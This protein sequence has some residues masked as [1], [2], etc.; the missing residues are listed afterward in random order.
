MIT[1]I[2]ELEPL[3]F[4]WRTVPTPA[5]PRVRLRGVTW[6]GNLLVLCFVL[7]FGIWSAFASLQSAAIAPGVV[8]LEFE[9]EDD[10]A[11]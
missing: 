3:E 4:A 8:E 6:T 9:P 2:D 7:G 1:A 10:L 11:P 5:S